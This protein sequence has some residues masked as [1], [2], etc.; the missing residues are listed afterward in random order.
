MTEP[1]QSHGCLEPVPGIFR[2]VLALPVHGVESVNVYLLRDDAGSVLVD[3]GAY[4]SEAVGGHGL[5]DL[6]AALEACGASLGEVRALFVTHPHVDHYGMARSLVDTTGA[7][8]WMHPAG[9]LDFLAFADPEGERARLRRVLTEHGVEPDD[10]EALADVLISDWAPYLSGVVEGTR[11]LWGGEQIRIGD[12]EWDVVFT[13]GH[14]RAH[15]CLWSAEERILL[16]GDHLLPGIASPISFHHGLDDD[17]LGQ[18]LDSLE[19]IEA[20]D[21]ALVL[22]GHGRPFRDGARRARAIIESKERRMLQTLQ[23]IE[24]EAL[25]VKE[26]TERVYAKAVLSYQV[27]VAM[28]EA[29]AH[30][31]CLRKRRLITRSRRPDGAVVF[32]KEPAM[33]SAGRG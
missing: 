33:A 5:G 18:Y 26:I 10:I 31:A 27:K 22:P 9:N 29:L 3:C 12:R 4:R 6:T 1:A 32:R 13:P 19:R 15:L 16:S 11:P 8:V 17:P 14:S 21:P 2:L 30:V 20:L 28:A 24:H 7:E 23:A 25:T